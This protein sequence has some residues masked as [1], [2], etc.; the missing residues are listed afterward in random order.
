[1]GVIVNGKEKYRLTAIKKENGKFNLIIGGRN[2]GKTYAVKEEFLKRAYD[3]KGAEQFAYIR[4][5]SMDLKRKYCENYFTDKGLIAFIKKY[6]KGEFDCVVYWEEKFYFAKTN[7]KNGRREKGFQIGQ[8][9]ALSQQEHY[10][11]LNYP[12]IAHGI[13]EEWN[14][15]KVYLPNEPHELENLISTIERDNAF[16]LY[17]VGNTLTRVIPYV[18]YWNLSNFSRQEQGTIDTYNRQTGEIDE[19]GNEKV[20]NICVEYCK[21]IDYSVESIK[22]GLIVKS[23]NNDMIK[24]G[25]WQADHYP[26]RDYSI[27]TVNIIYNVIVEYNEFK[28]LLRLCHLSGY[29][30]W[31]CE[32]K[33]TE[34]KKDERIISNHYYQSNKWTNGLVPL[35]QMEKR[36]FDIMGIGRIVFCDD[37]TG[38]EF[39]KCLAELKREA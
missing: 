32:R 8:A 36:A 15:N 14:T 37:L 23:K 11:S 35:S 39:Y 12:N 25:K 2:I 17:M 34:I 18:T 30:W 10:K 7:E 29:Y 1:M 6:T 33:T 27:K 20:F 26:N 38:T 31:D 13:F 5:W 24:L 19:N 3:S 16:K 9:F 22:K 28:F 4:R 21:E